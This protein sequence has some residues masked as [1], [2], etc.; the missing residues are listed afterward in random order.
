MVLVRGGKY[1]FKVSGVEIEGWSKP[2]TML[3]DLPVPA[4][5]VKQLRD[6]AG[7]ASAAAPS[8]PS[9]GGG[10]KTKLALGGG[11]AAIAVAASVAQAVQPE[12]MTFREIVA[13]FAEKREAGLLALLRQVRLVRCVQGLL[14]LRVSADAPPNLAARVSQCLTE[15]TGQRWMVSL[16]AEEGEKSLLWR[17]LERLLFIT[18]QS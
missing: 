17:D 9:G 15:W 3:S 6:A 11:G 14:E 18:S 2:E 16:S 8:T 10:G 13:L 12:A 4:D 7:S 5:L 1:R